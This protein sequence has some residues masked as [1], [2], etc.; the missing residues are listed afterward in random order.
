[1]CPP[2][3]KAEFVYEFL[4][5]CFSNL[6]FAWF[7]VCVIEAIDEVSGMLGILI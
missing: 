6:S 7:Q 3:L 2:N 1:V 4:M 5:I